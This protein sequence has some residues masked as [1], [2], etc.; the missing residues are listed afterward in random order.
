MYVLHTCHYIILIYIILRL[1][2]CTKVSYAPTKSV[3]LKSPIRYYIIRILLRTSDRRT[4]ANSLPVVS[5]N[6]T[7]FKRYF[8]SIFYVH[9]AHFFFFPPKYDS[10]FKGKERA[11]VSTGGARS[12]PCSLLLARRRLLF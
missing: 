1:L 5:I 2:T 12:I 7:D 3:F 9:V 11:V 4:S 8:F 10:T 6:F